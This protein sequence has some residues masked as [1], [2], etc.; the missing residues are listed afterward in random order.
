MYKYEPDTGGDPCLPLEASLSVETPLPTDCPLTHQTG[1]SPSL[2]IPWPCLFICLFIY[3]FVRSLQVTT[4]GN[5][6]LCKKKYY[7]TWANLKT[8]FLFLGNFPF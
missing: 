7:S 3:L 6:T 4:W 8:R 5:S 1:V 2:V